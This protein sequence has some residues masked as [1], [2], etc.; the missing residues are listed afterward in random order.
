MKKLLL[1]LAMVLALAAPALAITGPTALD[2]GVN[3]PTTTGT[4]DFG[5]TSRSRLIG[6]NIQ[7]DNVV[8]ENT[9][10]N[11]GAT[12]NLN[13]AVLAF[14]SNIAFTFDADHWT[15]TGAGPITI[16]GGILPQTPTGF[17]PFG[18]IAD[19][20][21]LMSGTFEDITVHK[22]SSGFDVTTS[23]FFDTKNVD[24]VHYFF[25][26]A[27]PASGLVRSISASTSLRTCSH[28]ISLQV[29]G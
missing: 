22:I 2:F 11:S 10:L 29:L 7:V 3:A 24:L 9:P 1:I 4:I 25:D 21:L 6:A 12:L 20:T 23:V 26:G 27:I 17:A 8:G 5:T 14:T 28:P 16:I 15:W 13:N 19:G 18:G